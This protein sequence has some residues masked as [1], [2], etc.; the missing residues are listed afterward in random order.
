MIPTYNN[1]EM[2]RETLEGVRLQTFRDF[3]IIVVDDG[4]TDH[5]AEAVERHGPGIRY[6]RQANQGPAAARNKGVSIAQ[7]DFI[8]FCD[9]DDVWNEQHLEKLIGC[10]IAHPDCAMCFD[11]A[12]G[13]ADGQV[14]GTPHIDKTIAQSMIGRNV[15][16]RRLWEC[17]VASMSVVMINK[18]I[19]EKLGGLHSAIWG[20]DDL[21][22]YL[23]LATSYDVRYVNYVGCKKRITV[24]NLLPQK[25]LEGIIH[26]LEDLQRN[27]PD[28]VHA[29]GAHKFAARLARR[30]RKLAERYMQGDRCDLAREMFLKA[31]KTNPLSL[32]NLWSYLFRGRTEKRLVGDRK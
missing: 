19:F 1:A 25:G 16:I 15:P 24:N 22:L 7:G 17:W 27:Y 3:E 20:L 28:V 26:C 6:V 10:F 21:H 5:T 23:R 32:E 2:L 8:A 14:V 9:H 18:Q 13:Y 12:E 29:V 4:S 31:F 30:Y 11:N